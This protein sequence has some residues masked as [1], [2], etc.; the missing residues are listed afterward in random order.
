MQ[1]IENSKYQPS[2]LKMQNN[3]NLTTKKLKLKLK[4]RKYEENNHFK[5]Y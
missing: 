2:N 1:N 5:N 4:T 3:K